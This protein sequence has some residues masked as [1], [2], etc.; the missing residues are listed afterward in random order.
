MD[1]SFALVYGKGN[2]NTISDAE[3][4]LPPTSL[5]LR[6]SLGS[7][8]AAKLIFQKGASSVIRIE[9]AF[10]VNFKSG[11]PVSHGD[12]SNINGNGD[13]HLSKAESDAAIRI[14]TPSQSGLMSAAQAN[15]LLSSLKTRPYDA[16]LTY[17]PDFSGGY[18]SDSLVAQIISSGTFGNPGLFLRRSSQATG[19][20]IWSDS[21][22][23]NSY[24]DNRWNS[25][26]H[27]IILRVKSASGVGTQVAKFTSERIEL[28]GGRI[29]GIAI[30]STD[31]TITSG[32]AC[33][34]VFNAAADGVVVTLILNPT[35][36]H[37]V[38]IINVSVYALTVARNGKKINLQDA[39]YTLSAG[40]SI[41]LQFSGDSLGWLIIAKG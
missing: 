37:I 21:A 1:D 4:A 7:R 33:T 36:G 6:L 32:T 15:E 30:Y 23:G 22:S 40:S 12:L 31:T 17:P 26:S 20:D 13:Y 11:M 24:I 18:V 2:Y 8:L 16:A 14:A 28:L 10:D 5:P 27:G 3:A 35:V 25:P 19:L 9:S 29:E 41:V 38:R 39:N 34:A